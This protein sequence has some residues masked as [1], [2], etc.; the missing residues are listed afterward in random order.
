MG[1]HVHLVIQVGEI[2]L[3]RIM[4]NLSFR[5]TIWINARKKRVG[6]LFQG[7]FKALL[8]D[9]DSYLLELI[10]YIHMN[11][12]RAGMV[13]HPNAYA[14]SSHAAYLGEE[15]LPWLESQFV[16]AQFSK[17]IDSA[18]ERYADFMDQG[19][20]EAYRSGFHCGAS[21]SRV[22]GDDD[23]VQR[24]V[25]E[26]AVDVQCALSDCIDVVCRCYK[27][28]TSV[29]SERSRMRRP[30][31]ARAVVAWVMQRY[32]AES[33]SAVAKCFCRDVSTM[34]TAVRGLEEKMK[35]SDD[36]RKRIKQIERKI[37]KK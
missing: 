35:K 37:T 31:E 28:E 25:A 16:L 9:E 32:G 13:V 2:S 36:L 17:R 34:S 19:I 30:A 20:H 4:Q 14:W 33:L 8:V 1:N 29:L 18:R 6:H 15:A 22:V 26:D 10:R 7:R 24:I 27:L 11:P 23:F 21:D 12:V 3:S 5:H